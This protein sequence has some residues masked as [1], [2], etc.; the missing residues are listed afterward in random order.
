MY[1]CWYQNQYLSTY[2]EFCYVLLITIVLQFPLRYWTCRSKD[3]FSISSTV[4]RL[5]TSCFWPAVPWKNVGLASLPI[6]KPSNRSWPVAWHPNPSGSQS[7]ALLWHCR[8]K[9]FF[10]SPCCWGDWKKVSLWTI[11]RCEC[12]MVPLFG[13][14]WLVLLLDTKKG[15]GTSLYLT[16]WSYYKR[17]CYSDNAYFH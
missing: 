4:R 15:I 2:S 5:G 7:Q 16:W 13:R 10:Q 1:W 17:I 3:F 12:N 6:R 8:S 9:R 11:D 14:K